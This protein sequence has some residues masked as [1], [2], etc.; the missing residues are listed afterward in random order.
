MI[1]ARATLLRG[2]IFWLAAC[3][4]TA[5]AAGQYAMTLYDEPAKY[6]ADFQHFDYVNPD[7]PKGGTLHL[8][9]V[10]GF[11][12]L[13][14]WLDKG[15]PAAE[16]MYVYDTLMYSSLDEPLT[17]YGLVAE[18]A[19]KAPDNTWVRFYLRPQARFHDGHPLRA[20]DVA[21]TFET[22]M[23]K[24]SPFWRNYWADV[25]DVQVENP[26]QVIFHFKTGSNRELPLIVGQLPVLPKHFWA[27][28]DFAKGGLEIPLGSGPYKIASVQPGRSLRLERVKDYW[29]KDLPVTRGMYNFDAITADVY[30]D[31]GVELEALKAGAIDW[32]QEIS[33]KNWATAYDVPAVQ[34]GKLIKDNIPN[35]SPGGMQGFAFNL[36]RPLFQDVRVRQAL[37]LMFD[38][39]WTN[40]Q[41]FNGAYRRTGSF[42]SNSELAASG[43]PSADE[44]K[45]LEPLRGKI[46]D[47]VFTTPYK[48][49][50]SDG[51]GI[52]RDQQRQAYQLLQSAGWKVVD[53]RMT[54]ASGQPV[55]IEFLLAQPEFERI[56]LPYKRNLKD[57]G[58]DL[59]IRRVDP[60]QYVNRRRSRDFDMT[61]VSLP[62]SSSPGNEQRG[63]WTSEA[64]DRPGT[65]NIMGLKD[66]AV[67]TL[68]DGLINASSRQNLVT[69]AHALDRVLLWNYIVVPNWTVTDWRVAYWNK[70]QHP[71][72]MPSNDI[73]LMTWWIRPGA[74]EP[75]Q[76]PLPAEKEAP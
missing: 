63:F 57:L 36:R 24:G 12:S 52:I 70:L 4:G 25:K 11:D 41:L 1:P 72:V 8:A 46:P 7:A 34:Q 49:P 39:E 33:A 28:R 42:F 55:T 14:P 23:Q 40:R 68:V 66:P 38:F 2:C 43:L 60:A 67:D 13:N 59:V 64:A 9:D 10:G 3:A 62:Q 61:V 75:E 69:Y 30:R 15:V 51:S 74:A 45:L 48:N 47:Q 27:S 32:R 71:K 26:L 73:G 29:A 21:F 76:Q 16:V 53:D 31:S 65:F 58:I 54:D 6:P 35:G 17:E 20:E 22:L 44:L 37:N 19:E 5:Q 18:R 56:L 50:V